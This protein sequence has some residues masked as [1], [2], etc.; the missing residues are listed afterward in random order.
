MFLN[1]GYLDSCFIEQTFLYGSVHLTSALKPVL[2][3][4]WLKR[5]NQKESLIGTKWMQKGKYT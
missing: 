2:K 3:S 5:G 1:I 4:G